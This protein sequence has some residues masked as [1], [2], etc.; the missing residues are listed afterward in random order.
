MAAG[1]GAAYGARAG[2]FL[3][4]R[5]HYFS[6]SLGRLTGRRSGAVPDFL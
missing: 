4:T 1:S 5:P 3:D 2:C 6:S